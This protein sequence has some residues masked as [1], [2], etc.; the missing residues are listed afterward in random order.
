MPRSHENRRSSTN[1][2]PLGVTAQSL[3]SNSSVRLSANVPP[4]RADQK[5]LEIALRVEAALGDGDQRA[6]ERRALRRHGQALDALVVGQ[7]L[8]AGRRRDRLSAR[9]QAVLG[10]VEAD[11]LVDALDCDVDHAVVLGERLGVVP[12]APVERAAVGA[13]DRRDLGIGDRDWLAGAIDDAAAQPVALVVQRQEI[14]AVGR[15]VQP[16]QP[17][18]IAMGRIEHQP[19]AKRQRAEPLAFGLTRIEGFDGP[20]PDLDA[21]LRIGGPRRLRRR[22]N[23]RE[24]EHRGQNGPAPGQ[25]IVQGISTRESLVS[26]S[27]ILSENRFTLFGIMLYRIASVLGRTK[28]RIG[29]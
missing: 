17:A 27:M 16:R 3:T 20:R 22:R 14:L 8:H 23:Q 11:D 1:S 29:N 10:V 28:R 6:C 7:R 5:A 9:A 25:A 2:S 13:E 24:R 26:L 18:E 19:A 15:N 21:L 4:R 12:A